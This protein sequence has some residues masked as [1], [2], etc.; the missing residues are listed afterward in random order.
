MTGVGTKVFL[1]RLIFK[2]FSKPFP[3][4]ISSELHIARTAGTLQ[5]S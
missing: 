4:L 5:E 3:Y 1:N 2:E